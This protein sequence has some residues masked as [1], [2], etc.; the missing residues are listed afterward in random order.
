MV[1]DEVNKG[2]SQLAGL[3][4][5][6]ICEK[7]LNFEFMRGTPKTWVMLGWFYC[8]NHFPK[9][10]KP[11]RKFVSRNMMKLLFISTRSW[12][13]IIPNVWKPSYEIMAIPFDMSSKLFLVTFCC[14]CQLIYMKVNI[15]LF[16]LLHVSLSK[17]FIIFRSSFNEVITIEIIIFLN[18][19]SDTL[20]CHFRYHFSWNILRI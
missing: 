20:A 9:T 5:P 12:P 3:N 11:Q 19:L 2:L 1:S 8:F 17:V 10:I 14:I 13:Q 16:L 15:S 4:S 6:Q 18:I 7:C